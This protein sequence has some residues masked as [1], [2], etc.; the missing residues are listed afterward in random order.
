MSPEMIDLT[1]FARV[2]YF[3][4][5]LSMC[6][7]TICRA[8]WQTLRAVSNFEEVFWVQWDVS[9]RSDARRT[10][11]GHD[12]SLVCA[13][14]EPSPIRE[15]GQGLAFSVPKDSCRAASFL[16]ESGLKRGARY[17]LEGAMGTGHQLKIR[18]LK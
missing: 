2:A 4:V 1:S 16:E 8:D 17:P 9:T 14:E 13:F 11:I 6:E 3:T 5:G 15:Q 10:S 18:H 7:T 12:L